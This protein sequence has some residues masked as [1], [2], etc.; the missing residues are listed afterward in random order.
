MYPLLLSVSVAH[1]HPDVLYTT[2]L[3]WLGLGMSL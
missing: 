2:F 3:T 1:V